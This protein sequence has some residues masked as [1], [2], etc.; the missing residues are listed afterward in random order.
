M[1]KYSVIRSTQDGRS[2]AVDLAQPF[3]HDSRVFYR[4][5]GSIFGHEDNNRAWREVQQCVEED[6]AMRYVEREA[7]R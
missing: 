6:K 4:I 3:E 2:Y 1:A 7:S 5:I